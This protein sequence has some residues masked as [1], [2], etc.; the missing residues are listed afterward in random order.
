[1]GKHFHLGDILSITSGILMSPRKI[2][3]VYDILNYMTGESLFTHQLP[4]ASKVCAPY[5]LERWPELA[6]ANCEGVTPD[7]LRERLLE[8]TTRYG[9]EL[10][11]EPLPLGG[12]EVMN[13]ISELEGMIGKK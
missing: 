3:G 13:P 12:Y 9:E 6:E 8:L 10:L 11:V 2:E 1:M 7:N 5:L 4:R